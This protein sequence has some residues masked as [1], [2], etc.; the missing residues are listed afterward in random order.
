MHPCGLGRMRATLEAR[1]PS[2]IEAHTH[3][4]LKSFQDTN[5]VISYQMGRLN[6]TRHFLTMVTAKDIISNRLSEDRKD[7]TT[8]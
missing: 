4:W 5:T 7:R 3:Q 8:Y 1:A 2:L 6:L